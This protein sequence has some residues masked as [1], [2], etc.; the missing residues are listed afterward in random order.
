MNDNNYIIQKDRLIYQGNVLITTDGPISD[1]LTLDDIVILTE[2][3]KSNNGRNIYCYDRNGTLKWQIAPSE[4]LHF[5]NYYTSIYFSEHLFL[6]AYNISGIEVTI[7]KI[8]GSIMKKEL[9]K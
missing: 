9:I 4:Q 2:G 7:N 8:D 1:Y 6:Q 3:S 5:N